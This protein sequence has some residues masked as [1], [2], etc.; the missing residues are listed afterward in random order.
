MPTVNPAVAFVV[1]VQTQMASTNRARYVQLT[2]IA[3]QICTVMNLGIIKL[4]ARGHASMIN[5]TQRRP[6]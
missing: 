2:T 5:S 1:I 4:V 3:R 6:S